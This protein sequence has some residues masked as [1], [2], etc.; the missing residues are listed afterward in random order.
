[1]IWVQYTFFGNTIY[2]QGYGKP[3]L[4]AAISLPQFFAKCIGIEFLEGLLEKSWELQKV[5]D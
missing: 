5:Y 2:I 3:C 4:A 1:M